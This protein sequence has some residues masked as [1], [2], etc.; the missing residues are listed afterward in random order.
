LKD[1]FN[2]NFVVL[3]VQAACALLMA[4]LCFV[5]LRTS[6]RWALVYWSWGWVTLFVALGALWLSFNFT[7]LEKPGQFMYLLG[8]YTYGYLLVAGCRRYV[9]N[10][11]LVKGEAWLLVPAAV[12]AV[13]LPNWGKDFNVFFIVHTLIYSYLF[14]GAYR[15]LRAA[16]P[17]GK[18]APGVRV[19]KGALLMLALVYLH[20]AP[21]FIAGFTDVD[22]SASTM[23]CVWTTVSK[24]AAETF[25]TYSPA[26]NDDKP[27]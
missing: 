24:P 12:I 27:K 1:F 3:L 6:K 2:P 25:R 18:S 14:F 8:E 13:V 23:T 22:R 26:G 21:I 4:S 17:N 5:L 19:L 11:R 15:V 20:Y 10:R 16:K 9:S 7:V